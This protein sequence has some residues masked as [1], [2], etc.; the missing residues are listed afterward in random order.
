KEKFFI[1]Y[2]VYDKNHL[3]HQI[4]K[5]TLR[6][7]GLFASEV[8]VLDKLNRIK[9]LLPNNDTISVKE[10]HFQ[11][12]PVSRKLAPYQ[13]ALLMSQ[14]ILLNYRPDIRSGNRDLIAILFDMNRL[15]EEFVL[16]SLKKEA[17]SNF[18]IKGQRK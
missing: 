3:I 5:E 13:S 11:K 16:Q 18:I 14:L 15:W 10:A 7:I 17:K 12:I 4:F 6:V 1:D 9:K 2:T 8:V